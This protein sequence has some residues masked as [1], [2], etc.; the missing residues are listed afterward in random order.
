MLFSIDDDK[1]ECLASIYKLYGVYFQ[2]ITQLI[3][4]WLVESGHRGKIVLN[5]YKQSKFIFFPYVQ[6][7]NIKLFL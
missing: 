1:T 7:C 5:I 3:S 4:I 2:L 6:I